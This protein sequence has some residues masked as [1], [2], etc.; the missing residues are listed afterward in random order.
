MINRGAEKNFSNL[1][2]QNNDGQL[3]K[4]SQRDDI[5]KPNISKKIARQEMSFNYSKM[6]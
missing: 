1:D 4:S 2:Y 5:S 6:I 3:D